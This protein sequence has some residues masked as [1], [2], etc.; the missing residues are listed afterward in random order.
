MYKILGGLNGKQN[1]SSSQNF[2][3]EETSE[4][5]KHQLLLYNTNYAY[6]IRTHSIFN[7]SL[8]QFFDIFIVN[9]DSKLEEFEVFKN[10]WHETLFMHSIN[11][12]RISPVIDF[13]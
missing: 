2:N 1:V 11:D 7:K 10:I 4:E 13:G 5:S 8:Q 6:R 12:P 3:Y 9:N